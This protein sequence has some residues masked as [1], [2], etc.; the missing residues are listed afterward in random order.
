MQ[1]SNKT[2]NKAYMLIYDRVQTLYTKMEA[3]RKK[4]YDRWPVD[5]YGIKAKMIWDQKQ[6]A[7]QEEIRLLEQY[8]RAWP[9][10]IGI[11]EGKND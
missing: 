8:L 4:I 2:V 9:D 3:E 6:T 11:M 1:S 5:Y 10:F 7:Y